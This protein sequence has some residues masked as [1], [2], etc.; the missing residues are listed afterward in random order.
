MKRHLPLVALVALLAF[1]GGSVLSN[2]TWRKRKLVRDLRAEVFAPDRYVDIG[3]VLKVVVAAPAGDELL[4]GKPRLRVIREHHFGGILDTRCNPPRL[5]GPSVAPVTWFCSEDQEPVILHGDDDPLGQVVYGSEGAGKTTSLVMWSYLR[6]LEHL[7]EGRQGGITAP[8]QTRLG[9]VLG[10]IRQLFPAEWF[11]F[12]TST[13]I[14]T[15]CDGTTIRLV[16]TYQQSEAQGSRIQGFNLSWNARDEGQDQVDVH[17]DIEARGRAAK[18]GRYKQ[19]ITATAKDDPDWR[20]LRDRLDAALDDQGKHLWIRRTLFGRRSPFVHPTFWEHKRATMSPREYARRV[21]CKDLGPERA[22]YYNWSRETNLITVPDFGWDDVTSVELRASGANFLVLGGHDPGTLFDVTLFLKAY[23]TI[24]RL[25]EKPK[26]PFWVVLDELTTELNTTEF[27]IKRLLSKVRER[28]HCNMLDARDVPVADGPQVLI[29]C[30]P[31][32]NTDNKTDRSVYVKF[33]NAGIRCKPAAYNAE[34]DGHG[35]VPKDPGIELVNTLFLSESGERRL[36]VARKTD[37]APAA[38]RLVAALETSQRDHAG[39]AETQRKN[40]QDCSH[41]PAALRYA[42]WA[43]ERPRLQQ[44]G[45][46]A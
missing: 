41:W 34:G 22:T 23:R 8:T 1:L 12:H 25:N 3:V 32:G 30:D 39:K 19:L 10:E 27:H 17:E 29:R 35:R 36:F 9:L 4:E 11:R 40:L 46:A 13:S 6:W 45:A 26:R 14:L 37:G 15:F 5:V 43:V 31:A 21:E 33:A 24:T 38:P 42:L 2:L 7:G 28:W 20:T 44:P 18:H 16:S